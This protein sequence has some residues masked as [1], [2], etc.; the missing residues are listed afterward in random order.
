MSMTTLSD[1]RRRLE[2]LA[3]FRDLLCDPVVEALRAYL[4]ARDFGNLNGPCSRCVCVNLHDAVLFFV[5]NCPFGGK[6]KFSIN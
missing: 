3:L 2:L 1:L 4:L 6:Y 5:Q